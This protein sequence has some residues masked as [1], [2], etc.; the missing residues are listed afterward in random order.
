M[1]DVRSDVRGEVVRNKTVA[2]KP[3]EMARTDGRVK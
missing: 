2:V 1:I 3:N